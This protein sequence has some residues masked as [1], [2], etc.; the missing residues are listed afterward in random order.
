ML[1]ALLSLFD[2]QARTIARYKQVVS[3]INDHE[4]SLKDLSDAQLRQKTDTFKERHTAGESLEALLPEAFAVVREASQRSLGLRHFDVQFMASLAFH[5]GKVAEQKTGEGKTLSATPAL[6]LNALA[7]K[8]S[9]LVTVNDYLSQVGAGWMG[10]I[11]HALGMSVGVIIHDQ[12]YIFDPE[13]S[14]EERGDDRLEHFRPV[15]RPEA[16]RADI[17]YG[18]NNE[19][20][21]DY[22]RDNMAQRL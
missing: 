21:F 11:Y 20:G 14:G 18:T 2:D 16:Y 10:P 13:F 22:L 3:V 8:G 1:K 4:A 19:F 6:Y 15:S 17:T 12:A 7:G 5:E 9:H